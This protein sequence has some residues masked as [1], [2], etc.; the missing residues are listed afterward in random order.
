VLDKKKIRSQVWHPKPRADNK[1]DSGP[2][3]NINMDVLLPKEFM[4]PIDS[5]AYDDELRMTQLTL[6]PTPVVF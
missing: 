2:K 5:D 6:E 1:R 4:V 3:G